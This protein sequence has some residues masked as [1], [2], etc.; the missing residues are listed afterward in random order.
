MF[1]NVQ[2]VSLLPQTY[3]EDLFDKILPELKMR[4][5]L[6]DLQVNAS[7]LDERK[8]P[9]MTTFERLTRL[10]LYDPTRAILNLLPDWL[11]RLS[12]SLKEL[13]LRVGIPTS[14][15]WVLLKA[16]YY[17]TIVDPSHPVSYGLLSH[18]C[19]AF[20]RLPSDCL[21]P[22]QTRMSTLR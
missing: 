11:E 16:S 9:I 5:S 3:H 15:S 6:T 18:I 20:V 7:C 17:R 22:S 19:K 4:S 13:H 10:T 12:I 21:I 2:T 8:A 14:F 1:R